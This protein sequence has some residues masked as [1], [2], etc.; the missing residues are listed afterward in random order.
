MVSKPC[1]REDLSS[2]TPEGDRSEGM[3]PG[4]GNDPHRIPTPPHTTST[5]PV[6]LLWGV[7]ATILSANCV[8]D[9]IW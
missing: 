3:R 6:V 4:T 9:P 7:A 5:R 1:P 2:E 8:A